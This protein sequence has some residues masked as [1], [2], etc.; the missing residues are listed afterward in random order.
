M[1]YLHSILPPAEL[2]YRLDLEVRVQNNLHQEEFKF[3]LNWKDE[4]RFTVYRMEY[5]RGSG[6]F[7]SAGAGHGRLSLDIGFGESRW[8]SYTAVFCGQ[9]V[10]DGEG[11][12]I[13]GCFG[14]VALG[15]FVGGVVLASILM[16]ALMGRAD[17]ALVLAVVGAP[18]L[19]MLIRPERTRGA[20][21]L[22]DAL[23]SLV[24]TID[25]LA[26]KE[27]GQQENDQDKE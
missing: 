6:G 24:E 25:G 19:W 16:A 12:T 23:E 14:Q 13:F 26:I 8:T 22:W 10:P 4:S 27:A 15:W 9:I 2:R 18:A 1:F 11:S 5:E 3:V 7:R 20:G 17:V 21:E